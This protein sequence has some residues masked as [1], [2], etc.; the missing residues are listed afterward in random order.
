RGLRFLNLRKANRAE[1]EEWNGLS[2]LPFSLRRATSVSLSRSRH[3]HGGLRS[4]DGRDF[5]HGDGFRFVAIAVAPCERAF[6]LWM[7][8]KIEWGED[9]VRS[10][11]STL[12]PEGAVECAVL[13][14]FTHV[15]G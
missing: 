6:G 7:A 11:L 10:S 4:I 2:P 9:W 8:D 15:L 3:L 13:N 1:E 5:Q 12:D 14:C